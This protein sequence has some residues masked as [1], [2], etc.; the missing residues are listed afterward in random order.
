MVVDDSIHVRGNHL[1]TVVVQVVSHEI[2]RHQSRG[3]N[4][5]YRLV[6]RVNR[7]ITRTGVWDHKTQT[8][9]H[10]LSYT[11]VIDFLRA[12]EK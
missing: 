5:F 8:F 6:L 12:T 2:S 3:S 1:A 11:T 7:L 10:F 9:M 4:W